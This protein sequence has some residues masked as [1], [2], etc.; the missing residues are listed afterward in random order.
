MT[1]TK[2]PHWT[3]QE[4]DTY[5]A[6]A[7]VAVPA[8]SEQI[9]A[10]LTLVPF[11]TDDAFHVVELASGE[12]RLSHAVLDAFPQATLLA[13]DY[14]A[15][16]QQ[17]TA[18]RI[19]AFNARGSVAG[20]DMLRDDWYGL[21]DGA[22][23]VV[24]SLCIHHLDG[25]GKQRLFGAVQR[26]LSERGAFLIADLVMPVRAQVRE[27][28]AATWDGMAE[29]ASI[30]LYDRRDIF[31]QF[32]REHWNYYRYPDDFDKPSPLADQL[33]WLRQAGFAQV[34]AF[35]M[36]AGHAIYGGYQ[37]QA[38]AQGLSYDRAFAAAS[39]A[40]ADNPL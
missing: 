28:F 1:D 15:S 35:W 37:A 6:L 24:S 22:D 30:D 4:S 3:Q 26:H 2:Q 25:A 40:L 16:M 21:L 20:F 31:E 17:E 7:Q 19:A 36:Q 10:L 34:D 18:S 8:R 33:V 13:L 23:V 9:A 12:G 11:S 29:A 27:L 39:R 32:V 5:R 14:E 38:S